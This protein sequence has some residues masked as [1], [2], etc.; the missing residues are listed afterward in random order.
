MKSLWQQV[1]IGIYS[2]FLFAACVRCFELFNYSSAER[3]SNVC[4]LAASI[5]LWST[6][7]DIM[8]M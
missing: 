2:L 1:H 5:K 6:H 3:A 4:T 8:N 7:A